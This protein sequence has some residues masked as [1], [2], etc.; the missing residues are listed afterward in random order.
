MPTI[1]HLGTNAFAFSTNSGTRGFLVTYPL[2]LARLL[3]RSGIAH[4]LP[5]T[6]QWTKG[7]TAV[8]HH[9]SDQV[10]TAPCAEL[11]AFGEF[12]EVHGPDTIDLALGSPRFDLASS[13]T[14]KL[15]AERRGWPPA[16]GLTELREAVAVKLAAEQ[17]VTVDAGDEVLITHGAAGA[18][19]VVLDTFVNA[20][21]R[22]VVLAPTSPLYAL[23]LK[24]RRA[25]LRW[26]SS[27]TEN[28]RLRF[29]L[30]Q[31]A[32][33]VR[34]A[35]L[36]LVNS[37]ANPTGGVLGSED[38]EQIAWWA[39]RRDA[40]ILSDEVFAAYHYQRQEPSIG[41]MARARRRTLVIGS[42][43]KEFALASARVGWL[44]G[45]R[46]LLRPCMLASA[47]HTPFVPTL[48]QQIALTALQQGSGAF[49]AIRA[50]FASRRRYAFERLQAMGLRPQWP[51]GAFFLWVGLN[52][53]AA[54][55][56]AFARQLLQEQ[57]VLVSPGDVFGP[58]GTDHIRISYA[59]EDGRLREGLSRMA[60]FVGRQPAIPAQH[61]P[62]AA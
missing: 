11:S 55:G 14:T 54:D 49:A 48:C 34:G 26:V 62:Q 44:A 61:P 41:A 1:R 38:L 23:A 9:Y 39:E 6:R 35:R 8:L 15:P 42:V 36:V 21:D 46:H 32:R 4:W 24:H 27:W 40:L 37:P 33:A 53:R 13:G 18:V 45:H 28:G 10:L 31:F 25:R 47:L 3:V 60:Q 29:R 58:G 59:M 57:K 19:S 30:D 43:S 16:T 20:R 56:R 50:Q 2:F 17:K 7:G 5:A 12:R 52:G 51:E 22:V